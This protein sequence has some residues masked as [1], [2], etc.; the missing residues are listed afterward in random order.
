M[1][2]QGSS[3]ENHWNREGPCRL[4]MGIFLSFFKYNVKTNVGV[5]VLLPAY[6]IKL[7]IFRYHTHERWTLLAINT[8]IWSVTKPVCER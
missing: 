7:C 1:G 3:L 8:C 6:S 4:E 2:L 5:L